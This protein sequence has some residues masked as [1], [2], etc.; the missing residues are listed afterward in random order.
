MFTYS[1]YCPHTNSTEVTVSYSSSAVS[2]GIRCHGNVFI[3][4]LYCP[5]TNR[6]EVTVSYSSSAVCVGIRYR[7]N[8]FTYSFC[9]PIRT[10]QK[11]PFP[12]VLPL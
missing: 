3:Y 11:S 8:V 5:H 12:A 9:V 1:L 4:S 7:G 10:V 6:T 2:V